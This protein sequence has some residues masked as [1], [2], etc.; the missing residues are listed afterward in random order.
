MNEAACAGDARQHDKICDRFEAEWRQGHRPAIETFMNEVEA[1]QRGSLLRELL[2]LDLEYRLARSERPIPAEYFEQFPMYAQDVTAVF[3]RYCPAQCPSEPEAS[4][5]DVRLTLTVTDGPQKGKVFVFDSHDVFIVGR[6]DRAHF[7]LM[8]GYF[9]RV[10]FLVEVN[11]PHC[12]ITDMGSLNGTIV[13]DKRIHT[14]A[15]SDGDIIKAGYTVLHVSLSAPAPAAEMTTPSDVF[16]LSTVDPPGGAKPIDPALQPQSPPAPA[17]VS[18]PAPPPKPLPPAEPSLPPAV[19]ESGTGDL[20]AIPG[21]RLIRQLGQG[22]MGVVYLGAR[23]TDGIQVAIKTIIPTVA[24]NRRQVDRFLREADILFQLQH[25]GIV[26]FR[27]KGE[28]NGSLFF[29][30]DYIEG[31]DAASLIKSNPLPMRTAVRMICKLLSAL[32]YAHGKGF[33]HRDIKPANLLVGVEAGHKI[34]KLADFG[35]ARVYQ[36]SQVSGLTMEGQVGGTVAFMP[37]EQILHFRDVKPAADQYSTAATLYT[38]LTG[39]CLFDFKKKAVPPLVQVLH[40]EPVPIRERLPQLS[41]ALALVIH[42]ALEKEP[43]ARFDDVRAFRK[44]LMPFAE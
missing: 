42:R 33:V 38:L 19:V 25:P 18:P 2:A 17:A 37:P 5:H 29:A 6:S 12:R 43:H 11:P 16:Q 27:D 40:E 41:E 26:A 22:G 23:Q 1:A 20:P 8:D 44:A 35:L 32:E 9:S 15:L 30:M 3:K 10:H 34:V 36:A 21:Y 7:Q 14:S 31:T 24:V 28:V 4:S 39:C 13:N